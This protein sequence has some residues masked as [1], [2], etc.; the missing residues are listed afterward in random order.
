MII[1][2]IENR[3]ENGLGYYYVGVDLEFK[4]Y[5]KVVIEVFY[6]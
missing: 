3:W 5:F 1:Y 2:Y 4:Y 6:F